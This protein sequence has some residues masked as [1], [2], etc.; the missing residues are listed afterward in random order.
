MVCA[1]IVLSL[2]SDI[3]SLTEK[4]FEAYYDFSVL[5][6]AT[7][8]LTMLSVPVMYANCRPCTGPT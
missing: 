2:S 1:V 5:G 8:G 7:A 6:V 4:Y 3:T